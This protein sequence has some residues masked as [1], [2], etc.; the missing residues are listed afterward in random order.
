MGRLITYNYKS[1]EWYQIL[2]NLKLYDLS[3]RV[4]DIGSGNGELLKNFFNVGYKNLTGIDPYIEKDIIYNERLRIEKK[5]VF[6]VNQEYDIIILNHSLE[7]MDHQQGTLSKTYSILAKNGRLLIRIPIVSKPLMDKY[8]PNLVSL[9]TPRHF[10][11]HS[12]KSICMLLENCGFI[13][14]KKSIMLM[15]FHFGEA[16]NIKKIS[17]FITIRRAIW[18]KRPS[19]LKQWPALK[20]KLKN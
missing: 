3:S 13:I 10:Y 18:L 11:I 12:L 2:K 1:S 4:L 20:K 15:N 7:H 19:S 8:G 9:D 14:E 5:T 16:N 17:A 6:D